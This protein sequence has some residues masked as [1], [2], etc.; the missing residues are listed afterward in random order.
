MTTTVDSILTDDL[1]KRCMERAPG[2]DRKRFL[3]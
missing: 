3:R 1:L 2:Y